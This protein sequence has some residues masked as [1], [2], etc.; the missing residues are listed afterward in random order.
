MHAL[1]HRSRK[2]PITA[3]ELC[4]VGGKAFWPWQWATRLQ[5]ALWSNIIQ[6]RIQIG[7]SVP[8]LQAQCSPAILWIS[9]ATLHRNSPDFQW[10]FRNVCTFK[11]TR[12][13][14]HKRGKKRQEQP[15]LKHLKTL[16]YWWK[17]VSI[18]FTIIHNI[19]Q[20]FFQLSAAMLISGSKINVS[21][22]QF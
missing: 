4:K 17:I 22:V 7:C 5:F 1:V 3:F 16:M 14:T 18:A 2:I 11:H 15:S 9:G 19:L 20:V 8:Q 13:H 6:G 12:A 10:H 21:H